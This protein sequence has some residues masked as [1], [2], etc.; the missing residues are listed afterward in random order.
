M[1]TRQKLKFDKNKSFS[2]NFSRFEKFIIE[3]NPVFGKMLLQNISE[4]LKVG[5]NYQMRETI[6]DSVLDYFDKLN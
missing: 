6:K 4:S 3:L 2:E 5:Q 1:K